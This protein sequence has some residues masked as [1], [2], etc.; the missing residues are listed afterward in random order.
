MS[1]FDSIQLVVIHN[2]S[3]VL[4]INTLYWQISQCPA[5]YSLDESTLAN[6]LQSDFLQ[7]SE[8][9]VLRA[10]INWS[11]HQLIRQLE[12]RGK[13]VIFILNIINKMAHLNSIPIMQFCTRSPENT[14]YKSYFYY[15]WL[16]AW[17]FQQ[18]NALWDTLWHAVFT[19]HVT[20]FEVSIL[21]AFSSKRWNCQDILGN[22]TVYE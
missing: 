14:R 2:P 1:S 18:N 5:L 22:A 20:I 8:L 19:L 12:S 7:A 16:Y 3:Y 13:S 17:K 9:D 4:M 21:M 11:E 10:I 15:H 6:V